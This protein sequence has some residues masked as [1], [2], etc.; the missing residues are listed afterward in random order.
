MSFWRENF[1]FGYDHD[2]ETNQSTTDYGGI[3]AG[4]FGDLRIPACLVAGVAMMSAFGLP[5]ESFD[6]QFLGMAKLVYLFLM[7]LHAL[8]CARFNRLYW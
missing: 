8:Y 6:A 4:L 2:E 7:S 3:V 5:I 1:D